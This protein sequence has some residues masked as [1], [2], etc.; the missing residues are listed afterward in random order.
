MTLAPILQV[1]DA[2]VRE[3]VAPGIA[4]TIVA[5]GE[6]VHTSVHGDAQRV[7]ARRALGPDDLFDVASLTKLYLASAVARL[8]E[9][10][11]V[12]LD[13]P[14]VRWIPGFRHEK[15]GI[16]I[17]HLLA[18]SAG[19]P[20]WRPFFAQAARDP[21]ARTVFEPGAAPDSPAGR[22]ARTGYLYAINTLGAAIGCFAAG[23]HLLFE[24]G[25]QFTLMPMPATAF[26]P[27]SCTRM[28]PTFLSASMRSL[29]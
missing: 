4:A 14:V 22:A 21:V 18:H 15:E 13:A 2:G 23:Y 19:L 1:A 5:R 27:E 20:G 6:V 25:V 9:R 29:R 11:A 16:T 8:V 10:G 26:S 24:F 17:R 28:P 12:P 3:G 7:P